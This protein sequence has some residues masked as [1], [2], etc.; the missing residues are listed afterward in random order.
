MY[1]KHYYFLHLQN[2]DTKPKAAFLQ[3]TKTQATIFCVSTGVVLLLFIFS[4][5]VQVKQPRKKVTKMGW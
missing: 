3:I 2:S 5:M 1:F 4:I